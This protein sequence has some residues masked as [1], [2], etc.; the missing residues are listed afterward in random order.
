MVPPGYRFPYDP[1]NKPLSS[2][3]REN[4]RDIFKS[5]KTLELWFLWSFWET[6]ACGWWVLSLLSPEYIGWRAAKD[7]IWVTADVGEERL[8]GTTTQETKSKRVVQLECIVGFQESGKVPVGIAP[9]PRVLGGFQPE[10]EEIHGTSLGLDCG[11][12][13]RWLQQLG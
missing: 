12:P 5:N 13:R 3:D 11:D 7:V 1:T 9:P 8:S 10:W 6:Q 4:K 2:Y